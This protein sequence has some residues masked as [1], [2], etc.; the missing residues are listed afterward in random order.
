MATYPPPAN[1]QGSIFNPDTWIQQPLDSV[2][3]AFLDANYCRYPV[4]QGNMNFSSTNTAG[5]IDAAENIVLN[6][7]YLTNYIQFP[8][9]SQQFTASAGGVGDALLSGG[10]SSVP[11]NFTGYNE[12]SNADGQITL[13]NTTNN[14]SVNLQSDATTT[15]QLDI[16]GGLSVGGDVSIG[17]SYQLST[18]QIYYPPNPSTQSNNTTIGQ[19][20]NGLTIN[21][22]LTFISYT[23]PANSVIM[24][25]DAAVDNQLDVIGTL[26]TSTVKC[27]TVNISN[28]DT[29]I[30]LT[31]TGDNTTNNKL[32]ISGNLFTTGNITL[33]SGST[34]GASL[35]FGD[36][37]VQTVAYT[38]QVPTGTASLSAGTTSSSPQTFT[39]YNQINLLQ[40]NGM[41]CPLKE[42][43]GFVQYQT[44]S[45]SQWLWTTNIPTTLGN[46]FAFAFSTNNTATPYAA[47]T[48]DVL[49][50]QANSIISGTGYA[51]YQP[52]TYLGTT[53]GAYIWSITG[54]SGTAS[55]SAKTVVNNQG[56]GYP[57]HIIQTDD[58]NSYYATSNIKMTLYIYPQAIV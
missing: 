43:S 15:G 25:A 10:T 30:L 35:T 28:I 7:T 48:N 37:T 1:E 57:Y 12:F 8:D 19:D 2:D 44:G 14:Y 58:T 4:A 6:G 33:G 47:T 21:N 17:S 18:T 27:G 23:T 3:T 11:Q 49:V 32:N 50:P 45:G 5:N 39:G 26:Q 40:Y 52:Y 20:G 54:Y 42:I 56:S 16:V 9:G 22:E 24:Y 29:S 13:T 55:L 34:T 31:C 41:S 38:G 36:G 53:Y 46:G 51:L